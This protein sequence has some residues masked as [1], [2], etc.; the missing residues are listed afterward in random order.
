ML[1]PAA[2]P[3]RPRSISQSR[4]ACPRA[5]A[6]A[7]AE[8]LV[9]CRPSSLSVPTPIKPSLAPPNVLTSR[10]F[11]G[12][13]QLQQ[14]RMHGRRGMGGSEDMRSQGRRRHLQLHH[15]PGYRRRHR[16]VEARAAGDGGA[17]GGYDGGRASL[18]EARQVSRATDRPMP[19][20]ARERS[21]SLLAQGSDA[22]ML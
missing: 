13:R 17:G 18:S 3:A 6:A 10:G 19:N 12:R 21:L 5:A 9:A 8:R 16:T 20:V 11:M 22:L 15:R 4:S 7:A 14:Q 1:L 2:M